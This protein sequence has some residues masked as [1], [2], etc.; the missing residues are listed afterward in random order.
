MR[1]KFQLGLQE[2]E[3]ERAAETAEVLPVKICGGFLLSREPDVADDAGEALKQRSK[4][5]FASRFLL[6]R[7]KSSLLRTIP[8]CRLLVRVKHSHGL[9]VEPQN[10][11]EPLN[12]IIIAVH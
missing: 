5:N 10:V 2:P 6:R 11:Q 3:I 7:R 8:L 12:F 1:D 4:V 9:L